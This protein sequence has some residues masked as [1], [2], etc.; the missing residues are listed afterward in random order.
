MSASAFITHVDDAPGVLS[1]SDLL[2][3]L[4]IDDGVGADDGERDALL[5]PGVKIGLDY[6]ID[7]IDFI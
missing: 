7:L 1:A 2:P 5:Q 3:R 4:G 6:V